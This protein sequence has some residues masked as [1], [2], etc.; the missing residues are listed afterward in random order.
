MGTRSRIGMKLEDGTVKHSYCHY[1]GYPEGVGKTL[2]MHYND[3]EKV[4][5][6]LSFGDMSCLEEKIHPSGIHN[7]KISEN[8][9]TLFY[10]RDRGD[11]DVDAQ[12]TSIEEFE[13]IKFT[14]CIDY[15]YLFSEGKWFVKSLIDKSGWKLVADSLLELAL[16]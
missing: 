3:I 8:G 13:S 9:V 11:S 5:E 2:E 12:V 1:D 7:F 6:L 4:E 16:M 15:I 14:T 10:G